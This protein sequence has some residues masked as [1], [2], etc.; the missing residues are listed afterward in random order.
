MFHTGQK[1]YTVW[2]QPTPDHS[3]GSWQEAP[4]E[5]WQARNPQHYYSSGRFSSQDQEATSDGHHSSQGGRISYSGCGYHD[6]QMTLHR[7]NN[8]L[9]TIEERTAVM[10]GTL[11]NHTQW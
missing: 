10:Q 11:H 8:K 7:I 1:Q 6:E 4:S 5:Q 3:K 2:S 9:E